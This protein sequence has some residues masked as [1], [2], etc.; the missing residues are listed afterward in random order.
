MSHDTRT[1]QIA[2]TEE[3]YQALATLA[4]RDH[5]TI[6]I[7]AHDRPDGL[8]KWERAYGS[9]RRRSFFKKHHPVIDRLN[10]GRRGER[11][12]MGDFLQ[13]VIFRIHPEDRNSVNPVFF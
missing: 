10:G 11:R 13:I 8:R 3:Q 7:I 6:E 4:A 5:K 9:F 1:I 12:A 2:V